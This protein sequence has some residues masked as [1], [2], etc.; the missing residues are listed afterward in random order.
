MTVIQ[1]ELPF[2]IVDKEEVALDTLV[3]Y[4]GNARIH[5]DEIIQASIRSHGQIDAITVNR[6]TRQILGG[7]GTYDAMVALGYKTGHVDWVDV[8]EDEARA[9][10]LVLNRAPDNATYDWDALLALVKANRE[11]KQRRADEIAGQQGMFDGWGEDGFEDLVAKVGEVG[12]VAV[13]NFR[14]D[15]APGAAMPTEKDTKTASAA[16]RA[17]GM[18]EIV[19]ILTQEQYDSWVA[20]IKEC[21]KAWGC[22][23]GSETA[24]QLI[25]RAPDFAGFKA[26]P[27]EEPKGL[28]GHGPGYD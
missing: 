20:K 28:D 1:H 3:H 27:L 23:S 25:A 24:V 8:D 15:Y 2:G 10:V 17:A 16:V 13:E 4:P 12:A 11:A 19:L 21:Q 7:N 26:F 6:R 14:G 18:K 22:Q 5:D 9:I